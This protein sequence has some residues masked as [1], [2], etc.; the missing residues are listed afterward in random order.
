MTAFIK[1]YTNHPY[2][3]N[4]MGHLPFLSLKY[5]SRTNSIKMT[6]SVISFSMVQSV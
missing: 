3:F 2:R 1:P 4:K 5:E 6:I